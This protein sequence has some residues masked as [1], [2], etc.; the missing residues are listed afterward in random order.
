MKAIILAGEGNNFLDKKALFLVKGIPMIQYVVDSLKHSQ[1]IDSIDVVGNLEELQP[2]IGGQVDRLIEQKESLMD[3]LLQ[4]LSY[5]QEEKI[6]V[7]TCDIPLIH[8]DIINSFINAGLETKGDI[9]YPIVEKNVYEKYYP[10]TKRTYVALKDG[11]FTGGN[12]VLLS[13]SAI[14]KI[15]DIVKLMIENRKNPLKMGQVLGWRFILGLLLKNLRI[16]EV[17]NY[18]G[19]RFH[20]RVR[21]IISCHPEIANDIDNKEDIKI[22]EK[23]L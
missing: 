18:I 19:K 3:N 9:Y 4:A 5:C 16:E 2:I 14:Y 1:Y 22:I 13:P 12:M 6:L 15:Q 23:Y 11:I 7:I 8:G 10:D 17:E 21:A 20:I